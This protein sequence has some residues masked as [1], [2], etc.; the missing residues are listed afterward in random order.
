MIGL[1]FQFC[2]MVFIAMLF[3]PT[4]LRAQSACPTE[5]Q[6]N[7]SFENGAAWQMCWDSRKRENI[8]LSDVYFQPAGG[9]PFSVFNSLRLSQLHVSYDDSNVVYNDVTEF[10]LGGGYVSQL[11]QA[12]CPAGELIDIGGLKRLCSLLSTGDDSY[13]TPSETRQSQ[14]LSVFSVSQVGSYAYLIT[15]KFFADGS[16]EASVGAAG[17]LQRSTEDAH[18]HHGR[19]LEDVPNK[20]WLS[21]THNY[22]WQLDFDL[23]ESA[24]DDI[25][26]ELQFITDRDGRRA[27]TQTPLLFEAARS[28]NPQT[29]RSWLISD[30]DNGQG[31]SAAYLIEPQSYGHKMVNKATEPHTEFD[32]FVT[33]QNDCERFVSENA[34]YYPDCDENILQF[35][36]NE[37]L[38]GEDVVLWHRISFHHVP[39]NE[40]RHVM[41]SHW[42]GFVMQARNLHA[43]T[44][45]H[46][47]Q[48]STASL[49]AIAN[50]Q[51]LADMPVESKKSGFGCSV[52]GD[53][54][55][56]Q[57]M[58]LLLLLILNV[59]YKMYKGYSTPSA[60][61]RIFPRRATSSFSPV[62]GWKYASTRSPS[63]VVP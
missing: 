40:D 30:K 33:K 12:D 34:K 32:F 45:G 27:M 4:V 25:V 58:V 36:N 63:G 59:I 46:S 15:W 47:G 14:S 43:Q 39:R 49:A 19:E 50:A 26:S 42:D 44:P 41:H 61:N 13:T 38:M 7:A 3:I 57:D 2:L 11:T 29:M 31:D 6:I 28:I 62:A 56:D 23:G 9:E 16:V 22:Y 1:R 37:S 53:T 10:G 18:S 51:A 54:Q 24:N 17:A 35:V 48:E 21:H 52:V 20:A 5:H 60:R 55:K 8:V